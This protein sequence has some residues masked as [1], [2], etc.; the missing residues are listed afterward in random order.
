VDAGAGRLISSRAMALGRRTVGA[1]TVLVT[2]AGGSWAGAGPAAAQAPPPSPLISQGAVR[3]GADVLWSRGL[4]GQGQSVAILDEGFAALDRSIALGELPGRERLVLRSFDAQF[5]IEG[6]TEIG[7]PTQHGVRM[8]ELVHDLAPEARLLLV[9]YHTLDEFRAAAEFAVAQGAQVVSHSNSFLTPPFDGTG[10]AARVVD[11]AAAAGV[12]W[13]NS[14]GNYAQRHWSGRPEGQPAVLPI[15]PRPGEPLALSLAWTDPD[16]RASVAIERAEAGGAFAEVARS[17]PRGQLSAATPVVTATEGSWRLV[18]RQEAGAGA[19]LALFSQTV[20]FGPLAVDAR[21]VP[22]PG[23]AA[24]ALTVGAVPW[25][26]TALAPYSSHGPTAD[27]RLK[28]ELVAPT[29][30][31]SNPEWPGTA[32]TSAATAHVAGAAALVR[33]DR[34]AR[35][36]PVG[37]RDMRAALSAKVLDLGPPGPDPAFG[38]GQ[39]RLDRA[40]PA[41]RLRLLPGGTRI[42][43]GRRPLLRVRALDA[44]TVRELRVA[45]DGRRRATV[46]R[47]RLGLRLPRLRPGRHR[48]AVSAEDWAGN[49]AT[50][51]RVLRVGGAR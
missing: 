17:A 37:P 1:L 9:N 39:V 42:P 10:P 46:R 8:A 20:G 18:V 7:L 29:Y 2:V 34:I 44:G 31:T 3:M 13:V 27:G 21:S 15:A 43:A 24:G 14:A 49:R 28:P 25:T 6:R 38:L 22:T 45:V 30:V 33:Q 35:G 40:A 50:R 26:G 32:G 5:G 12:L 23:D 16:A 48:L 36:L 11:A 19:E 41:L 51:V 4:L 47:A